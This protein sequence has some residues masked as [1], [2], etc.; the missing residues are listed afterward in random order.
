MPHCFL[1]LNYTT[2][3]M[4]AL[5][6]IVYSFVP[7]IS[8]VKTSFEHAAWKTRAAVLVKFQRFNRRVAK[9]PQRSNPCIRTV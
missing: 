6:W 1:L 5:L 8:L 3:S 9:T 7:Q 4:Y 2:S